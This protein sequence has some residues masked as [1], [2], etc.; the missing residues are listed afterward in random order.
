MLMKKNR[1][2]SLFRSSPQFFRRSVTVA[3]VTLLIFLVFFG[4]DL[5]DWIFM[6]QA[7]VSALSSVRD[8]IN[9]SIS[10]KFILLLVWGWTI[11]DTAFMGGLSMAAAPYN[12]FIQHVDAAPERIVPFHVRE[13]DDSF[14]ELATA[15][16]E[17]LARL[18][19]RYADIRAVLDDGARRKLSAEKLKQEVERVLTE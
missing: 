4:I 15:F 19:H 11:M 8:F 1:R 6:N 3:A 18:E 9:T 10:F 2:Q 13:G 14:R 12:R 17:M 7:G 5:L 16:N